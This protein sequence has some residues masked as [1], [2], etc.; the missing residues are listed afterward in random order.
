[1]S[2]S[3][4]RIE[5]ESKI[6]MRLR[7]SRFGHILSHPR[8]SGNGP[9]LDCEGDGH[10]TRGGAHGRARDTEHEGG[11]VHRARDNSTKAMKEEGVAERVRYTLIPGS[12]L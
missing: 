5:N 8:T 3:A 9:L 4:L 7:R 10:I 1:M 6:N 12:P 2:T 11:T